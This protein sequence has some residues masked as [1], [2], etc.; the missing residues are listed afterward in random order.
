MDERLRSALDVANT[1]V[2]F[3]TQKR[4]IKQKYLENLVYHID[5]YSF[6]IDKEF[7]NF[8]NTLV[9]L[10][11]LTDVIVL[12]NFDN[13][14]MIPDVKSFRDNILQIYFEKTNQYYHEYIKLKK[15]R[16]ISKMVGI[17]E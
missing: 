14:Y 15:N 10:E 1:M 11:A 2:T 4:L 3:N 7:V 16:S 8:L 12:D 5:G 17:D 13:P 6:N 9:Q